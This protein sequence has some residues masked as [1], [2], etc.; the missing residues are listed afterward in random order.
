MITELTPEQKAK[1]P[2]YVEK[3]LKIGLS[4][5]PLNLEKS[6]EAVKKIYAS[7]NLSVPDRFY[8]FPSPLSAAIGEKILNEEG[9]LSQEE[10]SVKVK[11]IVD[12]GDIPKGLNFNSQIYG[13][14]DAHWLSFYDFFWKECD[15]ECC[16][17]HE[18]LMELAKHC[19][20]WS[21]FEH[22]VIL[23]DRPCEI[24]FDDRNLSHCET[25]PAIK[26]R[27][28]FS[29]YSWHGTRIPAE[30]IENKDNLP[31][32]IALTWENVEQRRCA[33]EIIGWET[34]MKDLKTAVIDENK[35]PMIGTLLDVDIPEIGT[36]RFLR[37]LCG[38]GRYF[39]VPVDPKNKTALEANSTSYG[40]ATE[41]IQNLEVRT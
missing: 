11:K 4:T 16:S 27:D 31:V 40:V 24:H 30:W 35:D 5:E 17:P 1:M 12:S 41:I 7:G 23:Q 37:V 22:A 6:K 29:V 28:G 9:L 36:T 26:Y 19:G 10:V 33:C 38:T 32:E 39:S 2:E 20:W 8:H 21:P 18:G 13:A 25:G 3:W 14:H 34:V 15:L